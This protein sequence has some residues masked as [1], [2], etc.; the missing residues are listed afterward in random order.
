MSEEQVAP[1]EAYRF[2]AE[3]KQLLDILAHSLYKERDIWLRELISNA[4]DAL[5]RMHFESL[6]NRD[7]LDP[8]AELAIHIE[9]PEVEEGEPKKIVVK[10]SGIG[11]TRDELIENLSTIA[12]SGAMAFLK[13]LEE[14][15]RPSDIIGQFGVGFYSVFMVADEVT[16]TTRSYLL[17]G[18]AW[19]WAS[20]GDSRFTLASA[21]KG[22]R[23]TVV[24]VKL[25]EDAAEFASAWRL[26][27]IVKKHSDY[28]SFPIYVKDQVA[29]RQTALWRKSPQEVDEEEVYPIFLSIL[30]IHEFA[31]IEAGG[32]T[33]IALDSLFSDVTCS[34]HA[35]YRIEGDLLAHGTDGGMAPGTQVAD[36]PVGLIITYLPESLV[37]R[38][39]P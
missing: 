25:K 22:D 13:D 6:T 8:D 32:V 1:P 18:K 7:V 12:H 35:P 27:Q 28:V 11:M 14:G 29:N 15:A 34:E 19:R 9:V 39:D 17:D 3:I 38:V 24:E 26:E 23:G 20:S 21:E 2:K 31:A 33:K 16:V 5:T 30:Q 4:S 10:D 37:N 36:G